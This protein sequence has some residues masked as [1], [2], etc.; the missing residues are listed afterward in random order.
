MEDKEPIKIPLSDQQKALFPEIY[1][2][3]SSK[4]PEYGSDLTQV[5]MAKLSVLVKKDNAQRQKQQ[6]EAEQQQRYENNIWCQTTPDANGNLKPLPTIEN[7]EILVNKLGYFMRYNSMKNK[8]EF[9]CNGEQVADEFD[10]IYPLMLSHAV[11][12]DLPREGMQQYIPAV[13]KKNEYHPVK[14]IIANNTWDRVERMQAVIDCFNFSEKSHANVV[15]RKFFIGA[16]A[17]L[18]QESFFTKLIPVIQGDQSFKKTAALGRIFNIVD[19]AWLEGHALKESSKDSVMEGVSCWCCELGE[20]ETTTSGEQGWLKAFLPKA[21]DT[22]RPPYGRG[23][24]TRA[25]QTVFGGT[26]NGADFLKDKTGSTRFAVLSISKPVD[27]DRIN[28]IL[29]WSYE[30]DRVTRTNEDLLIQFWC[31]I[32]HYFDSGEGWMLSDD[33]MIKSL[34]V[35]DDYQDKGPYY[36]VVKD[37]IAELE[38]A[39]G[40]RS[41]WMTGKQVC[42]QLRIPPNKVRMVGK[43][44]KELL[45][46]EERRGRTVFYKVPVYVNRIISS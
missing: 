42:D 43:V 7:L 22:Y 31:E 34:A 36:Q 33:E 13:A 45:E 39:T 26:V 35:N 12:H 21:F 24:V 6:E 28:G 11:T 32:K 2:G 41:E 10:D 19:G 29:G 14:N 40:T 38:T 16:I 1:G 9:L 4:K 25:R 15:M 5:E 17:C 20:I 27:M 23:S 3:L 37:Y 30:N 44:F 8:I 18:F 46:N